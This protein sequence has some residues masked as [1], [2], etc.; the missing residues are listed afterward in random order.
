MH[1]NLLSKTVILFN[2]FILFR[3]ALAFSIIGLWFSDIISSG[4][5][6]SIS[7]RTRLICFL[8]L[9]WLARTNCLSKSWNRS[10]GFTI[11][12]VDK[13]YKFN[14]YQED[15]IYKFNILQKCICICGI[16]ENKIKI[17]EN[18]KDS[19][20]NGKLLFN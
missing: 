1:S 19:L 6:V 13:I 18:H 8:L 4:M 15:K 17:K 9:F 12:Q 3:I 10:S 7:L 20:L 14:I 2:S 5:F 16:V 11:Y